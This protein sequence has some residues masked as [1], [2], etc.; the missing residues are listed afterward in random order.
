MSTGKAAFER[1]HEF[2]DQ[3]LLPDLEHA[4]E[5]R[6]QCQRKQ[7]EFAE[8]QIAL[9]TIRDK[10]MRTMD[11]QMNLGCEMY[12][13]ARVDD[14][15]HVFVDVG[16]GF[17]AEFTLEEALT[18]LAKKLKALE[19]CVVCCTQP[20]A[21]THLIWLLYLLQRHKRSVRKSKYYSSSFEFGALLLLSIHSGRLVFISC[22]FK[23]GSDLFGSIVMMSRR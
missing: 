8:L 13:K 12:M 3:Q 6:E 1:F 11:A 2:A 17:H 15:S 21:S 18:F 14:T 9:E 16:L 22:C 20:A 7:S 10:R 23:C 19:K 4:L 5:W